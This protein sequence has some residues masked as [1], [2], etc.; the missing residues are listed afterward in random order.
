MVENA[1]LPELLTV[2]EVSKMLHIH[3]NTLRRWTEQGRIVA[4][5]I[6]PRGDRRF[7]HADIVRFLEEFNP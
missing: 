4:C 6:A 5:R 1:E 7:R 2:S 3:P